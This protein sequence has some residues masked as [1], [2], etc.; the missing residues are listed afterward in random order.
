MGKTDNMYQKYKDYSLYVMTSRFEGFALV[1]IEAHYFQL[2]V[3]SFNCNCGPDEIIQDGIN[4]FII[5]CFDVESMADKINFLIENKDER[6][7]MSNNTSLDKEKLNIIKIYI[8]KLI[9]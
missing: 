1:N 8:F 9:Y 6:V 3:V 4:G 2:P 5:D 7:K